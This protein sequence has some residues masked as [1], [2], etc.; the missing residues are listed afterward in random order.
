[1]RPEFAPVQPLEREAL[2]GSAS[3]EGDV[4]L[5]ALEDVGEGELAPIERHALRLVHR[6][7]PPQR[8]RQLHPARDGL[9]AHGEPEGLHAHGLLDAVVEAH[10]GVAG[11]EELGDDAARPVGQA[12]VRVEGLEQEDLRAHL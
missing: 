10:A 12:R 4:H 2:E 5:P 9:A 7:R 3:R 8:Q 1:M 11:R 6:D